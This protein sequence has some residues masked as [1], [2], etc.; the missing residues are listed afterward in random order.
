LLFVPL[1]LEFAVLLELDILNLEFMLFLFGIYSFWI[2]NLFG[3]CDF[4]FGI[5][6]TFGT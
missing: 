4:E 1:N 5:C 3:T 2:W 6:R